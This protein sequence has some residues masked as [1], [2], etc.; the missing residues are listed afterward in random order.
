MRQ[1]S[2]REF[3]GGTVGAS[4]ALLLDL[5][6]FAADAKFKV[7]VI[8]DEISQ[9]FDHACHVICEG[10]RPS[11]GRTARDLGQEPASHL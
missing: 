1:L 8:S 3:V 2:R 9:D 5:R 7:G 10:L 4:A 11:L 6:A